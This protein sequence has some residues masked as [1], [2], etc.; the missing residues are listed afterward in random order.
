MFQNKGNLHEFVVRTNKWRSI[1]NRA[2]L[3]LEVKSDR[4]IL[5][6]I[7]E[8]ELSPENLTCD[9][10]LPRSEVTAKYNHFTRLLTQLKEL[11]KA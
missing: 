10:E 5:E 6:E 11:D 8:S 9:G 1:W 4:K 3:N 7:I 2:P